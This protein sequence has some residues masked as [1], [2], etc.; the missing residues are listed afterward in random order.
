LDQYVP[1]VAGHSSDAEAVAAIVET[2]E[3]AE[4]RELVT[5]ELDAAARQVMALVEG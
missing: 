1:L 2:V 4:C 3:R 5:G